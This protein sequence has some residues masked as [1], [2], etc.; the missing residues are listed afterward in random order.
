MPVPE[1]LATDPATSPSPNLLSRTSP[2]WAPRPNR[3]VKIRSAWEVPGM[4]LG[5]GQDEELDPAQ[6]D[7]HYRIGRIYKQMGNSAAAEKEFAKVRELHE[8]GQVDIVHQMS[9]SPPPLKP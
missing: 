9:D 7:A 4:E 8:Q 5:M 2:G 1:D 6:P 3:T